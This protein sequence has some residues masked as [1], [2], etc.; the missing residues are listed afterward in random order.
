M[1]FTN[2]T[3]EN[4]S[5]LQIRQSI[6]TDLTQG[7]KQAPASGACNTD[8]GSM[9]YPSAANQNRPLP[10][11]PYVDMTYSSDKSKNKFKAWFKNRTSEL[12]FRKESATTGHE[13]EPPMVEAIYAEPMEPHGGMRPSTE[14]TCGY[15][16]ER[17][18]SCNGVGNP[19]SGV[20]ENHYA[21][22]PIIGKHQGDNEYISM[23]KNTNTPDNASSG[24][25]P[26]MYDQSGHYSEIEMPVRSEDIEGIYSSPKNNQLVRVEPNH[27][28]S[29]NK[30]RNDMPTSLKP[31]DIT[32][33]NI[34]SKS[35]EPGQEANSVQ[36]EDEPVTSLA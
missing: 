30:T 36:K 21:V 1:V 11:N 19:T 29:T 6:D 7:N 22:S 32:Y 27:D 16:V 35:S 24:D 31:A 5:T 26:P 14:G 17:A 10:V 13:T 2:A 4:S 9:H 12:G 28:E 20:L 23:N 8:A 15:S 18:P 25:P 3:Y 34:K 33:E